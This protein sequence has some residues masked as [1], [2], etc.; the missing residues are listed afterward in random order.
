LGAFALT[1]LLAAKVL[2]TLGDQGRERVAEL[3]EIHGNLLDPPTA[4]AS[5]EEGGWKAG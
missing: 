2:A 3:E 1:E 4:V 5:V